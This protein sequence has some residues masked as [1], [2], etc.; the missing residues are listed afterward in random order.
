MPKKIDVTVEPGG[1]ILVDLGGDLD[2]GCCGCE[3]N[4]INER[5]KR[6]GVETNICGVFCRLP[7][8]QRIKA[9]IAGI[10]KDSPLDKDSELEKRRIP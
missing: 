4:E 9:K 2:K 6:L 8:A 10:C 7:I 3:A 5:L 1:K